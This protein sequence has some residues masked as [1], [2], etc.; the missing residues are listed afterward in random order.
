[1]AKLVPEGRALA[2]ARTSALQL[3]QMPAD[4]PPSDQPF[5]Y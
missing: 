2:E 1:M 5:I 3:G 4:M